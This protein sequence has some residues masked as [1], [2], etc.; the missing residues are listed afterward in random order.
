MIGRPVP[1]FTLAPAAKGQKGFSDKDLRGHMSVINVF[2]SWCLSCQ[3]EQDVLAKSGVAVYGM[4]Y[5]D[6]PEKLAPWLK[7]YGDPYKAIGA[8]P[9]GRTAI[10]WGVY[11]VPETFIVDADGIIRD[12]HVG[13]ITDEDLEKLLE[14]IK[15]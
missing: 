13:A 4:N 5:K 2:A 9:E 14:K 7:K 1:A 6:K 12:K 15:R 11:G 10:N 3:T 8:D